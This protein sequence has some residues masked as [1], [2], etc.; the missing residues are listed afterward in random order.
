MVSK[1]PCPTAADLQRLL[2][3]NLP[4][5]EQMGVSRHLDTCPV[6]QQQLEELAAEEDA[7][8]AVAGH[9]KSEKTERREPL[10]QA[11]NQLRGLHLSL[12]THLGVE[13]G[14]EDDPLT[15]LEPPVKPRQLGK[16][17][18]Y[19]IIESIGRGGMGIVFKALDPDLHRI[20]AIKVMA[21]QLAAVPSARGRFL[22][23]ARATAKVCHE[24]VITIH[25]VLP[26]RLPYLVMQF[27]S[28]ESLQDRLE[29]RGALQLE[30][31]LRIGMQ[32][33]QGLAAAH[34]QGLVHRDIKPA[35]ILLENGV[36]RVKITD[37]GLARAASDARLTQSGV[38]V[39]TP[40]YM[41]PEQASGD[42]V[43]HRADLFSLGSVLYF[44]C[45]GRSPFHGV[46]NMAVIRRVCEEK[47]PPIQEINPNIPAWLRDI[48]ARLQAKNPADRIQSAA[49]VA[50]LLSRHL[51][52]LQRDRSTPA[53]STGL[54]TVCMPSEALPTA[55]PVCGVPRSGKGRGRKRLALIAS[56]C[57]LVCF[58]V[59]PVLFRLAF[60]PSSLPSDPVRESLTQQPQDEDTDE[61]P[62]A[63]LPDI[64]P[65][66]LNGRQEVGLGGKFTQVRTGGGGRYLVFHLKDAKKLAIFDVS[67]VKVV[68]EIQLDTEDVVYVCGREKLMVILPVNRTI[69]RYDLATCICETT[70]P[71]PGDHPVLKAVMG[72]NSRG[73]LLLWTGEKL[74]FY[75]IERMEPLPVE[76]G[77]LTWHPQHGIELRVSADG[78]TFA[79]WTPKISGGQYSAMRR[80]GRR[81]VITDST[82]NY[83]Y[84]DHWTLPSADASLFFHSGDR[85]QPLSG[86]YSGNGFYAADLSDLKSE[87]FQNEVLLPTEDP[88]FFL[89]LRRQKKDKDEVS[90]CAT[91]ER[92]RLLTIRDVEKMTTDKV[93]THWGLIGGEPR[94]HYLHS[95]KVL[96]TLPESN[97]CVVVRPLNLLDSVDGEGRNNLFV[98][99]VPRIR[100][101]AGSLCEYPLEIHSKVGGVHCQLN[102]KRAGMTIS[103]DN[104]L[105]WQVPEN[106]KGQTVSIIIAIRDASNTKI[107]HRID[108]T[109]E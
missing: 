95:A 20:V 10:Q 4:D 71:V 89:A 64:P 14:E 90:I 104:R 49:E 62:P 52:D 35:N 91:A 39:G 76:G 102:E 22:R 75:D 96:L 43:D 24:H 56:L 50:E 103:E 8:D 51:L 63:P 23:E 105:R 40:Q 88:R 44:M 48:I 27:V 109:V 106:L 13:D 78:R 54:K 73:P 68:N 30:E 36:E 6:C 57:L 11:M 32:I 69:Q 58:G 3:G 12:P 108:I 80:V 15:F 86:S 72:G 55:M 83:E 98:L 94:I 47:A 60:P 87:E 74:V 45:T 16:L 101:R 18:Q 34:A 67:A 25:A 70:K 2:D 9:L 31:I 1:P 21:P 37:F 33:A 28:G 46:S 99:S 17:D 38:I 107:S 7:W 65:P 26:K 42:E 19:E 92:R 79:G 84:T 59:V 82:N 61:A 85:F 100:F 53:S 93:P 5:T 41:A 97:D 66:Q 81:A 77:L 29:K